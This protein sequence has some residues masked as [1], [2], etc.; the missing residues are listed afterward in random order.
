MVPRTHEGIALGPTGNLQGSVKFYCLNTGRVLKRR[1][2]TEIPMPDSI[3]AR[4]E[5][6]GKR[7]KQGRAFEFLN[8]KK[9]PFDWAGE[10]A[11]DDNEFQ[12]LLEE[13][14]PFPDINNELPG[15][16]LERD[17]TGL[18]LAVEDEPDPAFE[19]RA[20]EAL[21]NA[22]IVMPRQLAA[23]RA[24]AAPIVEAEPNE[25]VFEIQVDLPEGVMA[26]QAGGSF[27]S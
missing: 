23:A 1:D 10:V 6:I 5:A 17:Q 16:E 9:L 8:R 27:Q 2:F 14:A 24:A 20:T 7:E 18:A 21:A 11:D 25:I 15:V 22:N 26:G 13:E 12:G 19:D 3:I 4:V